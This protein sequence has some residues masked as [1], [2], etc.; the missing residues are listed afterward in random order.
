MKQKIWLYTNFKTTL[1]LN[2][3]AKKTNVF[4][5]FF[6]A[7]DISVYHRDIAA[8]HTMYAWNTVS[9]KYAIYVKMYISEPV[10]LH[11][12]NVTGTFYCPLLSKIEKCMGNISSATV[13]S[14]HYFCLFVWEPQG[15]FAIQHINEKKKKKIKK[16]SAPK[17]MAELRVESKSALASHLLLYWS[18]N[19]VLKLNFQ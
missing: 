16:K 12:Q 4:F 10:L 13:C 2:E 5:I 3:K 17:Q 7:S 14:S 8:L 15:F 11:L 1:S 9:A 19:L 18:S 6:T